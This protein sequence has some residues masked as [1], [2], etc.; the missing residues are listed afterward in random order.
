MANEIEKNIYL[1]NAPAGSGKTTKIKQMIVEHTISFPR[2]NI[3]CITYTNRAVDELKKGITNDHITISTIHSFINSLIS[4]FFTLDQTKELYWNIFEERIQQRIENIDRDE[5]IER[6]N[7]RYI[8]KHGELTVSVIKDNIKGISYGETEFSSLYYGRLSHDDLLMFARVLMEKYPNIRKKISNKYQIIFIDE[9]QDTS[10]DVLNIFYNAV[11]DTDIKLYFLGDKMQQIYKTYDGSFE[12]I[13]ST[14]NTAVSLET[15]HRSIPAIVDILNKLYNNPKYEQKVYEKNKNKHPLYNPRIIIS[16]DISRDIEDN[17]KKY[18]DTLVL[19][20]FNKERFLEIGSELLWKEYNRLKRYGFG[21]KY[22]AVNVLTDTSEDNPDEMMKFLFRIC[23]MNDYWTKKQ[24]GNIIYYCK[25]YKKIF[26]T[27]VNSILVH[28]DKIRIKDLWMKVFNIFNDTTKSIGELIKYLYDKQMII[29][30]CLDKINPNQE[31]NKILEIP[32][33]EISALYNYLKEPHISTQHGVKGESHDTVVF[34]ATD[35]S[36]T[37]I[38]YMYKFFEIWSTIDFSLNEFE[39]FYYSYARYVLDIQQIIGVKST[40]LNKELHNK[41]KD[42]F[43]KYSYEI[44]NKYGSNKIFNKIARGIYEDYLQ[45]Q[46]VANAKKCFKDSTIYGVLSAY[47][48]FYVGCSRARKNLTI[49]V[50][51]RKINGFRPE[52]INKAKDIGF[53]VIH[54]QEEKI[55]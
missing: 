53:D 7:K 52:F 37:P 49:I 46:T 2:D 29:E 4:P 50:D 18:S 27:G 14:F 3:L 17:L 10:A 28:A 1:V 19:Y 15:N 47:R 35:S 9:Y 24:Y 41:H 31:Y 39:G 55:S 44:L 32:V 34:V 23:E 40:E 5:K 13:F 48:L 42:E 22:S 30:S 38:T 20:L 54:S 36:N 11:K 33:C 21:M 8:D 45:N 16:N 6:S 51:K 43:I 26:N 25:K 12:D